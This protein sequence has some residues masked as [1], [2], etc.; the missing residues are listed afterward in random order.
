MWSW[1]KC[2]DTEDKASPSISSF[3]YH[4]FFKCRIQSRLLKISR[5]RRRVDQAKRIYLS[6]PSIREIRPGATIS[7][8]EV[9]TPS[10]VACQKDLWGTWS[11]MVT[12][13]AILKG[14]FLMTL[15]KAGWKPEI[16]GRGG[17][18]LLIFHENIHPTDGFR[19]HLPNKA[20]FFDNS[21]FFVRFHLFIV[22]HSIFSSC[23]K[24][25]KAHHHNPP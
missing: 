3:H 11:G 24:D 21:V 4:Y 9:Y 18:I 15:L 2:F 8:S 6:I 20:Y 12:N 19:L 1:Q 10:V 7:Q 17:V 16:S 22:D 25:E 23:A 14:C 13:T 5:R